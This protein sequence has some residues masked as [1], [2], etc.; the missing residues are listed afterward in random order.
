MGVT[1]NSAV[2]P[3]QMLFRLD[4]EQYRLAVAEAEAR[5]AG[6]AQSIGAS[7][8]AVDVAQARVVEAKAVRVNVQDQATRAMELVRRG[9]CPRRSMMRPRPRWIRQ[10][11]AWMQPKPT[12]RG[13]RRSLDP[14]ER[15]IRS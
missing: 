12:S 14:Q 4:P 1:D 5:L 6:V 11:Q 3:G 15:T 13:L 7:T 9:V 10:M 2:T 8:A